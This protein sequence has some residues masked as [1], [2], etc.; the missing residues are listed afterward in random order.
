M[1]KLIKAFG[2]LIVFALCSIYAHAQYVGNAEYFWDADP[3][4]GSGTAL[5]AFDGNFDGVL[6]TA[7]LSTSSLPS[8]GR[9]KL[10]VRVRDGNNVWG[11]VFSTLIE[12]L[13]SIT[14]TRDIKV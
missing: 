2:L 1:N 14:T 5:T 8:A 13:P 11:P 9:H 10:S 12:V 7:V 6:E 4:A 3:G